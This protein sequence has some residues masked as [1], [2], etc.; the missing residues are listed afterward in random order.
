M[1]KPTEKTRIKA[2]QDSVIEPLAQTCPHPTSFALFFG[3][4]DDVQ[5]PLDDFG[6]CRTS[7]CHRQKRAPPGLPGGQSGDIQRV[8]H[9]LSG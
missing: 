4:R 6:T 7:I 9:L 1:I 8:R 5:P 3:R 2:L